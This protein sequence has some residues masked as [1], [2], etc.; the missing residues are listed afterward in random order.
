MVKKLN[1]AMAV[2]K[3]WRAEA[4]RRLVNERPDFFEQV[5]NY[6]L[7]GSTEEQ[8]GAF[9]GYDKDT[10]LFWMKHSP[11]L[12]NAVELGGSAA[13]AEVARA[14]RRRATGYDYK[15]QKV[16][17]GKDGHAQVFDLSDH[18]P[19]DTAAA[20][21]WLT[22][23]SN[24][25]SDKQEHEHRGEVA[26]DHNITIEFVSTKPVSVLDVTPTSPPV[27]DHSANDQ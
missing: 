22:N 11:E 25:W 10:W 14:L 7:L 6:C 5:T 20:K 17:V 1:N 4:Y 21:F 27:S 19:P 18:I 9:F 8:L 12:R 24:K 2:S 15:R 23:R 3:S 26:I 16:V 13:D